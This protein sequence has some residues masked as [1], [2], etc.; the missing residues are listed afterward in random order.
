M[1]NFKVDTSGAQQSSGNTATKSN[2][3]Y[4]AMNQEVIDILGTQ[5]KGKTVVGFVS[6]FIDLGNQP[7]PDF[8]QLRKE[9]DADQNKAISEGNAK[10]VTKDLYDNGKMH[11]G[12]EVFCNPRTPAKA[13]TLVVDFPQYK[14]DKGKYFG[15]PNPAPLRLYM[16]NEWLLNDPDDAARKMRIVQNHMYMTENTNNPQNQ[17]ALGTTTTVS[18][19]CVAAGLEDENGLVSKDDIT[20]LLGKSMMFNVQVWNKPAKKDASKSYYTESIKFIGEVPEGLTTP[21]FDEELIHGVNFNQENDPVMLNQIRHT[22]KNTMKLATDWKDSVIKKEIDQA[23]ADWKANKDA[24]EKAS[25]SSNNSSEAK[26]D[27][28]SAKE[29]GSKVKDKVQPQE[30][31]IDFDDK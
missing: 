3:D 1:S 28:K 4:D 19:M 22:A 29:G 6:G 5:K 14:V 10:V 27:D 26:S 15:E 31:E 13:F 25:G 12:V 11:R 8:E 18:K 2:V 17:W 7:R 9:D 16:G 23:K 20:E 21:E 24:E 30:A